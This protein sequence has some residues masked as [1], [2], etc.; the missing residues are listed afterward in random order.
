MHH[1]RMQILPKVDKWSQ[2]RAENNPL[3]AT[4]FWILSRRLVVKLTIAQA[5]GMP[6]KRIKHECWQ[7]LKE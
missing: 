3:H 7:V 2:L 5:N 6:A 1:P 4:M